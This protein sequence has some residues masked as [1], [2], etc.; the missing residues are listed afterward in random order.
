MV[1]FA[2]KEMEA[3]R[4]ERVRV[5]RVDLVAC[6]ESERARDHGKTLILGMPV[7]RNLVSGRDH[8]TNDERS[9]FA[10]IAFQD[11]DLRAFGHRRRRS[12]P[13]DVLRIDEVLTF[14]RSSG[15]YG[16]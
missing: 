8:E 6:P 15:H 13:L 12:A 9:R 7:R 5:A 3:A 10:R 4:L 14:A 11:G 2:G 1:I 16:K